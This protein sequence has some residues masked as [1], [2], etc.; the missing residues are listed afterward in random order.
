MEGWGDRVEP[1]TV[2]W[3]DWVT[4]H[5]NPVLI[6]H[7]SLGV[8]EYSFRKGLSNGMK[9]VGWSGSIVSHIPI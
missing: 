9:E 3:F 5:Q 7:N 4:R 6:H 8:M 2:Y 1:L